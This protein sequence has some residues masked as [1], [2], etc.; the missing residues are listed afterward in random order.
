MQAK[1]Y[2]NLNENEKVEIISYVKKLHQADNFAQQSAIRKGEVCYEFVKGNTL[3]SDE[4]AELRDADKIPVHAVEGVTKIASIV[5]MVSQTSKDGVVVGNGG[6][7]AASAEFRQR[8]LKDYI[9]RVSNIE[10]AETQVCQDTLVTSCPA[11]MWLEPHDPLDSAKQGL[12]IKAQPW[13]SVITDAAWRDPSMRDM[14]RI[15]RQL[16]MSDD[17]VIS[18]GFPGVAGMEPWQL[19]DMER[20]ASQVSSISATEKDF[21]GARNG[22]SYTA[23]GLLNVVETLEWKRLDMMCMYDAHGNSEIVPPNWDE[24]TIQEYIQD[25]PGANV[26]IHRERVLWVTVWTSSGI[27]LDYGPHWLQ[28]GEFPC[29]P[30]VPANINGAWAGIIEFSVDTLKAMTYA[31]TEHLQGVRTSNN[32]LWKMKVGSVEDTDEFERERMRPG[33]TIKVAEGYN[34]DDVNPVA[35]ARESQTHVDWW[36]LNQ[37]ILNRLTVDRNFEGGAQASQ[38][39][40]K[41]IGARIAQNINK[42]QFFLAGYNPMRLDIRRKAVKAMPYAMPDSIAI[43]ISDPNNGTMVEMQANEPTEFDY[44]GNAIAFK[45]DLSSGTWDYTFTEADNSINGKELSRT[46]VNEFF[47]YAANLSPEATIAAAKSYPSTDIQK[48]GAELEAQQEAARNAPPPPPPPPKISIS[49]SGE[50]IGAE[51]VDEILIGQKLVAPEQ[52]PQEG[53]TDEEGMIDEPQMMMQDQLAPEQ[54]PL[55]ELPPEEGMIYE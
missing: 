29:S 19:S 55:E 13:Q 18:T 50:D 45:N 10:R 32:N 25:H 33:G 47:K 1:P 22:D 8:I 28:I 35:S 43:R 17:D 31:L 30:F 3:T 27:L 51:R 42:L 16:Q 4:E 37:E 44:E 38:E 52:E 39:S 24:Q 34:L 14:R 15:H 2:S 41:A 46:V 48:Y 40:S 53:M 7:D 5:G 6:E 11:F 21:I 36:N 12:F 54:M 23:A 9:E 49:L 26:Q 20:V